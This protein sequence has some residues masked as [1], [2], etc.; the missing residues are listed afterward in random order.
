MTKREIAIA[1][2]R[3]AGYEND[4]RTFTRLLVE[5]WVRR[6]LLNEAWHQGRSQG[7]SKRSKRENDAA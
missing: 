1:R 6:E 4:T 5:S 7:E 3:I 2:A